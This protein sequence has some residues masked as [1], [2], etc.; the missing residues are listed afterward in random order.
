MLRFQESLKE[1]GV[2][3]PVFSLQGIQWMTISDGNDS[4]STI[5]N[6]DLKHLIESAGVMRKNT[7]FEIN[8]YTIQENVDEAYAGQTLQLD[9]GA[10]TIIFSKFPDCI[11]DPK[12]IFDAMKNGHVQYTNV[13]IHPI[14]M[15]TP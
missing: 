6:P 9:V 14:L 12:D 5:L 15:L 3:V 13:P 4:I 2:D 7:V 11:G 10:I 1:A 8:G